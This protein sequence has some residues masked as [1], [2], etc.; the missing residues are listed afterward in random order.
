MM[1][2][3]DK[4]LL[5]S[6]DIFEGWD[7]IALGVGGGRDRKWCMAQAARD[8]EYRLPVRYVGRTP[9]TTRQDLEEWFRRCPTNRRALNDAD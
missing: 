8:D 9:V 3:R 7:R 5:D 6:P 4:G 1:A 2:Y